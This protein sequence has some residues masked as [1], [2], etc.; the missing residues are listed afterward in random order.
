MSRITWEEERVNYECDG[1]GYTFGES[2]L[3]GSGKD[4]NYEAPVTLIVRG[5][6]YH[7]HNAIDYESPCFKYWLE[8]KAQHGSADILAALTGVKEVT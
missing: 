2:V 6:S 5:R 1:C 3:A 7:F 8:H 4:K